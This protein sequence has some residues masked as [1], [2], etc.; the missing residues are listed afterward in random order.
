M[1]SIPCKCNSD[2]NM[3]SS[4]YLSC[5]PLPILVGF[6]AL[7]AESTKPIMVAPNTLPSILHPVHLPNLI[8]HHHLHEPQHSH[9]QLYRSASG[10]STLILPEKENAHY[11]EDLVNFPDLVWLPRARC[12]CSCPEVVC[13]DL[14]RHCSHLIKSAFVHL[15]LE[16]SLPERW[17]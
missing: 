3:S 11:P 15:L 1:F 8:S 9:S 13:G 17:K 4:I 7:P 14:E 5:Y 10:S 6:P 12:C 2:H 16:R